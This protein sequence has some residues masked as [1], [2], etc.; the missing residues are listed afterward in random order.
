MGPRIL[1]GRLARRGPPC[2][3]PGMNSQDDF[4]LENAIDDLANLMSGRSRKP[5]PV[6]FQS[7][8]QVLSFLR[9]A[10]I[11]GHTPEQAYIML[12]QRNFITVDQ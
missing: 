11:P 4:D 9:D 8:E 2:Y 3:S 12:L 1:G 7:K 6:R 5:G 10:R